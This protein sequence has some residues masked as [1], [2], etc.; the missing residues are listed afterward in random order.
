M[1]VKTKDACHE[2]GHLAFG[3]FLCNVQSNGYEINRKSNNIQ[4][5]IDG[6]Q[7]TKTHGIPLVGILSK[8]RVPIIP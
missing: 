2:P 8:R 5:D 3:G 1:L 6:R 7:I 4:N